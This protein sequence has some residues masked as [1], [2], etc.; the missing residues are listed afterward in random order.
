MSF[1]IRPLAT[2]LPRFGSRVLLANA[3]RRAPLTSARGYTTANGST[4]KSSNNTLLFLGL[5]ALGGAGGYYY[6]T[7]QQGVK[8]LDS[9]KKKNIDYNQ[10][11]KDIA[12]ILEDN[13]YDDGSYGPV[14]LRLAWHASGTYD[15][16][17]KT[18]GSNGAT[19]RFEPE[20]TH[21]ANN[22]LKIA[23]DLLEKIHAKYP[24]LSYG[25]LWTLAGVCAIQ[26]L[27]GPTIPWRPGRQDALTAE[28]CTP[29]GR[30]PD[31]AQKEK[32]ARDIFYRMGFNDQEIVAL[33]GGHALGRC[34][35]DRSGFDG[36]WIESP[37]VFSND[38]F[39]ALT[40]R[41]W[42]KKELA[43]GGWQYVDKNNPDV[44]MLPI[45]LAMYEDKEFKKYFDEYAKDEAKFFEDFKNAFKKLIELGV[46]FKG[47]EKVYVFEKTTE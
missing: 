32:H 20:A 47:D 19:M 44:M 16:D 7:S 11:Y 38:Y 36:P 8:V 24:E 31:A 45:E 29:D 3:A 18:G 1:T 10:V 9:N 4:K 28:S 14:L 5:A 17:T 27:G 15:K 26:E 13:D 43:N 30:L 39:K 23:R 42:I 22:G 46:P 33:V 6:H 12:E 25:D 41:K 37:T 2:G 21:G 34:H 40:E 35:P